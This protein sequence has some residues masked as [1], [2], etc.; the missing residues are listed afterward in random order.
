MVGPWNPNRHHPAFNSYQTQR[1]N[2]RGRGISWKLTFEQWWQIW[3]QSGH[4]NERGR[5]ANQYCMARIGDKGPYAVG[6]VLIITNS[7][8]HSMAKPCIHTKEFKEAL[9]QRSRGNKY[10]KGQKKGFRHT[11]EAKKQ[12]S[13][14]SRKWWKTASPQVKKRRAKK[15]SGALLGHPPLNR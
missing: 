9:S 6:N 5:K 10:G 12:I 4:L 3:E 2:A 15:I 13:R 7:E 1:F 11:E 14:A 8:N